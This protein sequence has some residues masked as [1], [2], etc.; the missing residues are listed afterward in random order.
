[1]PKQNVKPPGWFVNAPAAAN[2]D[3]DL[4][5]AKRKGSL[6]L[7][8]SNYPLHPERVIAPFALKLPTVAAL[9]AGVFALGLGACA[10]KD[11]AKVTDLNNPKA[12]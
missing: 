10:Q 6:Q 5:Q 12:T 8:V 4:K 9:A 3:R 2:S 7:T 11:D 1:M